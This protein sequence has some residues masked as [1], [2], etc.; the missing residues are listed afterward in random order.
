MR[1]AS[2][3]SIRTG[4]PAFDSLYPAVRRFLEHDQLDLAID[5]QRIR[6][7]RTP[8]ARSVWIRDHSDMMR[9][10]R[11]FEPDLKSAV[12]HF[13]DTQSASGRVFDYFTTFPE[14]LPSERENWTKYVRVP[15]E[16]DV[17]YRF[18]K[19]AYLAWQ[20]SGD[21][22]WVRGLLP[23]LERAMA[24][25]RNHP[26]YW[27]AAHGLV[28]RAYTI[29]TWD[30]AY[31]AGRHDWLQF[32]I[33]DDTYW[34]LMHG[35]NSGYYEAY[36]LLARLHRRFGDAAR[37][38][39]WEARAAEIRAALNDA[40]WNGRF[41]THFVKLTPV[42]IAGVDEAEQLSLSN[43]MD[44]NRGVA[45][46]AQA[47]SIL[48]EY[49]RRRQ[50]TG[51]FAEWFSIDPPFPDGIF[52]DER[53]VAGAYCN[54]GILPLVGGE[55]ARAAFEHGFE[56]YRRRD[57]RAV[58]PAHRG[59]GRDLPVVLPRRAEEHGRDQHEPRRAADRRLGLECDAVGVGRGAGGRRGRRPRL[60]PDDAVAAL[61]GGRGVRR[62]GVRRV[63]GVW[64]RGR[65]LVPAHHGPDRARSRHA[66]R[67]RDL[68][69]AAPRGGCGPRRAPGHARRPV[70]HVGDRVERLRRL[71]R[72][73]GRPGRIH[74]RASMMAD[75]M[76]ERRTFLAGIGAAAGTIA[77]LGDAGAQ[78]TTDPWRD[79]R[80]QFQLPADLAYFNTGGLGSSPR[81][82]SDR[83]KLEMDRQDVAPSAAHNEN[84]WARIRGKCATLLGPS[85]SAGEIAFVS[86]ATEGINII[87]NGLPLKAGDEIITTTH[88]HVG[89][90]LPLAHKMKTAGVVVRTFAP[91]LRSR[92]GNVERIRA[93]LT[94]RT[95]LIFV[96]HVTC[97][98]GQV[99]PV[100]D[101]GRL[102]AERRIWF[103]LDGA[104]SLAHFPIDIAA[105]GAHFYTASCHK[106]LMGP[107]R[108]GILYVRRD[109]LP[110][111]ASV[112]VGA[113]SEQ[114]YS[115]AEGTVTLRA[116]A[117]RFEY[118]TQNDALVYGIE[119]ATDFVAALGL[120]RMWEHSRSL[121]ERCR[122]T[123]ETLK[124]VELVSAAEP[125][126]RSAIVTFRIAGRDNR[127][128]AGA[129]VGRRLRVRSLGEAGLNAVR[130]SFHVC[131]TDAEVDR[132]IE[133][134]RSISQ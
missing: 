38:Q 88:E 63:R 52:G 35:D 62:G 1:A 42:T 3:V 118:G 50:S 95:R 77:G 10:F 36:R 69:R 70:P 18:V 58:P 45:G 111:L 128:V 6:G 66:A 53:L 107:K 134:V 56:E 102:A 87:L 54:G 120:P 8:D 121:A 123:L 130:A 74:H 92:A 126:A 15:V 97:T 98:T 12:Q 55:L 59:G 122:S 28:K 29:D 129:L 85:C 21:D 104:Q 26:W 13:A 34:G 81:A 109:Q 61:A 23:N 80:A 22:E 76:I 96:S 78:T 11:Y 113:Y 64:P 71:R 73:P 44:I 27:D 14:K 133:G 16:A 125:E 105:T 116:D 47:A 33:T 31:T 114:T 37:A 7:Y 79:L 60:R 86:T 40:C 2:E 100:A 51:A 30:F 117:Q 124:S 101:I 57:S 17:E 115:L 108:T 41:Y 19:G 110:Q 43:P 94:P 49:R 68:P 39:S 91:D 24:Y 5:G 75:T 4:R 106:W 112:V 131:N 89:L 32:Q 25:I 119:A 46:H 83:V 67:R 93:L 48:R 132:L 20:A 103:A 99:L 90:A 72:A 84:D 82:V 127:Q 9:G 65:L